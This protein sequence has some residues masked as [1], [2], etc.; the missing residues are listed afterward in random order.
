MT[1]PTFASQTSP[2]V[3]RHTPPLSVAAIDEMLE[4]LVA[5]WHTVE[6]AH[7]ETALGGRICDLHRFNFLLWHE[8]DIARSPEVTD[9]RIA[10]VKRAIDKYN[11]AR[12]DAIE[13]VDDWLIEELAHR[14]IVAGPMA[15]AATETPGAAIDRLSILELRRFHMQE[16]I[17]RADAAQEHREKAASRMA[18]LDM[19]RTHLMDA[20]GRLIGEIFAGQRP[21]RVFRQMKMYNDPSMNP[22]LYKSA[23][24]AATRTAA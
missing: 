8:E 18:V 6:P 1:A 22:Y 13:K 11:Q 4:Y 15:P 21:L 23:D 3:A 7:Q 10:Q 24:K 5:H 17:D 19:Q 2:T 16:Q 14:G 20:L 9:A 12:N